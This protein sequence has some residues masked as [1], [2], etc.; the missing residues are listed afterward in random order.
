M[1]QEVINCQA[2]GSAGLRRKRVKGRKEE[3]EGKKTGGRGM[4]IE[5]LFYPSFCTVVETPVE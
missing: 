5:H 1:K 4:S 3:R 2:R